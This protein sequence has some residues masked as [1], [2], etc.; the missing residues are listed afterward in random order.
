MVYDEQ[1]NTDD[2]RHTVNGT[3]LQVVADRQA[4]RVG[5]KLVF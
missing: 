4:G 3:R 1:W 5:F 2:I